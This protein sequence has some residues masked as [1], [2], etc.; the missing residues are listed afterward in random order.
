MTKPDLLFIAHRIPYPPDKGDKIRSYHMLRY[1]AKHYRI[2]VACMIDDPAEVRYVEP[3][4]KMVYKVFYEVRTP[5]EMKIRALSS[6]S[7][8]FV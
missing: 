5:L 2:T 3:L 6:L 7:Y 1:L 8:N 4:K